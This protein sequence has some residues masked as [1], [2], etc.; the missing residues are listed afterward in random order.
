M[1]AVASKMY[2]MYTN[3]LGRWEVCLHSS[4]FNKHLLGLTTYI[5][6]ISV[7]GC[8]RV[9]G[10]ECVVHPL[11]NSTPANCDVAVWERGQKGD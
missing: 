1:Q 9:L 8:R 3:S 2:L 5:S 6:K 11:S 4:K 10:D 7:M